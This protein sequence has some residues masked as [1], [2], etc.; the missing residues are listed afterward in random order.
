MILKLYND[1]VQIHDGDYF[2]EIKMIESKNYKL[3]HIIDSG[4]HQ[5]DILAYN[6]VITQIS[7]NN[8]VIIDNRNML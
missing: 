1:L 4:L 8:L 7:S 6:E 5:L 2:E 3:Q